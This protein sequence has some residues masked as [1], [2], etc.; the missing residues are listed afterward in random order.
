MPMNTFI[1]FDRKTDGP[2]CFS[3]L[4]KSEV[5]SMGFRSN[6]WGSSYGLSQRL[7]CA[8]LKIPISLIEP[9]FGERKAQARANACFANCLWP[10]FFSMI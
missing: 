8:G 3:I 5:S 6:N 1:D 9:D 2:H 7:D 4:G 10:Q